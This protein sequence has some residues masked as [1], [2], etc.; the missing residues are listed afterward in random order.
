MTTEALPLGGTTVRGT[1]P[2]ARLMAGHAGPV[3][4]VLLA[5][6]ALWYAATVWM[7]APFVRQIAADPAAMGFSD[8]L[9]ATMSL[10]RPLLPAPHQVAAELWKT[11]VETNV[12]SRRSLVYHVWVTLSSTLLGFALGSLFG[13]LLAVLIVH[14]RALQKSLMPWII[15]SQTIPILAIA[16]IIIVVLGSIGLKGLVPKAL[17]SAYLCF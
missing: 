4:V 11:V 2:V 12:T 16:P 9:A 5:I 6:L 8:L 14:S 13:I 10:E 1:S 15:A 7:N 3:A 17:I